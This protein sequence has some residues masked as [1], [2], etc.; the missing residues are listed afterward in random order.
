LSPTAASG[1][2]G[3]SSLPSRPSSRS[4]SRSWPC[5][6]ADHPGTPYLFGDTFP[7]GLG[8][9]WAVDYTND[10]EQP[11]QEYPFVLSTGRV[12]YHWHGGAMTRRSSLDEIWPE[13]TVEMHPADAEMLDIQT[14]DWVRVTSRRGNI[15]L[16]VLVT[17]RSPEGT[18]FIPFHFV[19]AAAN[20]LTNHKIDPRAKIP[21]FKVC[22]VKVEKIQAP[23]GRAVK[24]SLLGERG[25]IKDMA[26]QVH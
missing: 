16:R 1:A 20:V 18:V 23:S 14:N 2:S 4:S 13:A 5:P 12:L 15:E 19:E 22:A 17:G 25:A 8:K 10:S 9:F 21:D 6:A 24:E 11:D 3:W 7:R 26:A